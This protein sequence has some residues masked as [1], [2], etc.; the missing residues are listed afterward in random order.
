M[1][2]DQV[3]LGQRLTCMKN[4]PGP[5]TNILPPGIMGFWKRFGRNIRGSTLKS[6]M[7]PTKPSQYRWLV[8]QS[9]VQTELVMVNSSVR[10]QLPEYKAEVIYGHAPAKYIG[11]A[12]GV[13][14]EVAV[15]GAVNVGS[16]VAVGGAGAVGTGVGV[17]MLVAKGVGSDV[18]V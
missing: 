5:P 2:S 16:N 14:N 13:G 7:C 12:V 17:G 11:V 3:E 8:F 18:G 6:R 9:R 15:G 1:T 10:P 4:V